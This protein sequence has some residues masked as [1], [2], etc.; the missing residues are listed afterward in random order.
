[1]P[2]RKQRALP[3]V[4]SSFERAFKGKLY[5]LKVVAAPNGVA[6]Q[7]AGRVFKAPSAAAKSIVKFAV[8]GWL[9]WKMDKEK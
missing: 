2:V 7:V 6:Y 8:N 9:F 3:R 5:R 4:G 1:M